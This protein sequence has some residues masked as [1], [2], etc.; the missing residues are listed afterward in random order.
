MAAAPGPLLAS[1]W[2]ELLNAPSL[3]FFTAVV[4]LVLVGYVVWRMSQRVRQEPDQRALYRGGDR[5]ADRATDR[6][7][8]RQRRNGRAG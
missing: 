2:R 3:F 8:D 6:P 1:L 7:G 4:H 5:C